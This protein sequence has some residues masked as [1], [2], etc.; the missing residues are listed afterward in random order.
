MSPRHRG[1]GSV[2][3]LPSRRW[4]ATWKRGG[5]TFTA[6]T[7]DDQALTFS[8]RAKAVRW[9][10]S[11]SEAIRTGT[12]PPPKTPAAESL[13]AYATRWMATRSLEQ[14]TRDHYTQLLR[15]WILPSL[16]KMA[17]PEV[18]PSA[19]RAWHAA[20]GTQTGPTAQAHAYGLLRTILGTAVADIV[21]RRTGGD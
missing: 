4:Q 12:W 15:D 9:L 16:G 1:F 19:V 20:L 21:R 17:V 18:T 13:E 11:H 3:Q 6:R 7:D 2:R 14:T 5:R 8:S 10:E